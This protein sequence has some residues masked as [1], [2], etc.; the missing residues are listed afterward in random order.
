MA[1]LPN[2]SLH[3]NEEW[4]EFWKVENSTVLKTFESLEMDEQEILITQ[5]VMHYIPGWPKGKQ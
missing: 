4:V 2:I 5:F 1:A 3:L